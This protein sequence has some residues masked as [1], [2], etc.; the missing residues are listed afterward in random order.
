MNIVTIFLGVTVG[1]TATAT[2]FLSWQTHARSSLMG[3]VAFG[4]GT[5]G[6]VLLA[7]LMNKLSGRRR[8]TP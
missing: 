8:S 6:G 5:A 4:F 7:K 3:V 2:T 1:A